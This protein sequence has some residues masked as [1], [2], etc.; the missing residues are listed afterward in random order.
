[1]IQYV[2]WRDDPVLTTVS[3]TGY[4]VSK[5]EFPA[6]TICSLGLVNTIMDNAYESVRISYDSTYFCGKSFTMYLSRL[7]HQVFPTR[8]RY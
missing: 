3:T 7:W 4:P 1:M 5:L 8:L 6:V 2:D